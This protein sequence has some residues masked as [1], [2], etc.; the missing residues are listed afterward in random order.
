MYITFIFADTMSVLE[1]SIV[2]SIIKMRD[3]DEYSL[4]ATRA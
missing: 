1:T 3:N 2:V 4:N